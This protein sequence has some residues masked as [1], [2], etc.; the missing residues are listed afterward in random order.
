MKKNKKHADKLSGLNKWVQLKNRHELF[1][2]D[3]IDKLN[4]TEKLMAIQF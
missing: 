1:D 4:D 2:A 3:Y